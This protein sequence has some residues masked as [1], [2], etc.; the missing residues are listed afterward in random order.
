MLIKK[1]LNYIEINDTLFDNLE[2]IVKNIFIKKLTLTII[3]Y[4]NAPQ[5]NLDIEMLKDMIKK[6][7][8]DL[9][10]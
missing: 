2:I 7:P 6:F 5:F 3:S 4:Y 9:T 1:E 10:R 8:K